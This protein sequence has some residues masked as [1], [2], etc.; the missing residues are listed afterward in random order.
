[1]VSRPT[2]CHKLEYGTLHQNT[3]QTRGSRS[4]KP[5]DHHPILD[6]DEQL[7]DWRSEPPTNA[8]VFLDSLEEVSRILSLANNDTNLR[9]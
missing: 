9:D 7:N 6:M 8:D 5:T 3:S 2:L 4:R 1:M